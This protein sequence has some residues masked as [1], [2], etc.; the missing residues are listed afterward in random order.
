MPGQRRDPAP[1]MRFEERRHSV[2]V[3]TRARRHRA[4]FGGGVKERVSDNRS[5]A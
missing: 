1:E 3:M 2:A 5:V 4:R